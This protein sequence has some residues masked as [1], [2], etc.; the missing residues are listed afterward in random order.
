MAHSWT[1]VHLYHEHFHHDRALHHVRVRNT[2]PCFSAYAVALPDHAGDLVL[3][4]HLSGVV[5]G[6]QVEVVVMEVV[7]VVV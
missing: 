6:N 5:A 1:S 2:W 4:D 7:V 3:S